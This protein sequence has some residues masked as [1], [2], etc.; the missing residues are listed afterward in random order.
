MF[1][2]FSAYEEVGISETLKTLI[3]SF[4]CISYLAP[5]TMAGLIIAIYGHIPG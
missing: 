4:T 3:Y 1:E 2:V 5:G